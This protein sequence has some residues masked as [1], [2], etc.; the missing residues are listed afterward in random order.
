MFIPIFQILSNNAQDLGSSESMSNIDR[1]VYKIIH[2]F[3]LDPSLEILLVMAFIFLCSRQILTFIHT[4]YSYSILLKISKNIKDT[5]YSRYLNAEMSLIDNLKIGD[6]SN[7]IIVESL[8]AARALMAPIK[9]LSLVI[10]G[11]GSYLLLF[12]ISTKLMLLLIPVVLISA[13]LPFKWIKYSK[14]VGKQFLNANQKVS[15]Y[16][17]SRVRNLELIKISG[18]QKFESKLFNDFT[19]KQIEKTL[20]LKKLA[21]RISLT[22]EPIIIGMCIMLIYLGSKVFLLNMGQISVF[23]LLVLKMIPMQK[24]I[25][26]NWQALSASMGPLHKIIDSINDLSR[27]QE[28]DKGN[29]SILNINSNIEFKDVSFSYDKNMVLNRIN[30]NF[31]IGEI[32]CLLGSSGAGKSTIIDLIKK[33]RSNDKGEIL[34][35]GKNIN[36]Y[37]LDSLRK[38]ISFVPQRPS[39][40]ANTISGH[41]AYGKNGIS[42]EDIRK[43]AALSGADK[44]IDNLQNGYNTII[45]EDAVKLSGGQRQRLDIAR[46]LAG[47]TTILILDEPTNDLD[48]ESI[49]NFYK[50]IIDINNSRDMIIIIV[51]HD[52][53]RIDFADKI[54]IINNG[55]TEF[56]G[57]PDQ[58]KLEKWY[59]NSRQIPS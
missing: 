1:F 50:S 39:Y 19:K 28:Q 5:F 8:N 46:A 29:E 52:L 21:S 43:A 38:M 26:S 51:S 14:I 15:I 22:V 23:L 48:Q 12:L 53:E 13:L 18:T 40:L 55:K 32:T 3:G 25:L 34:I 47:D 57:S 24:D 41:I 4:I 30:I 10:N 42:D 44:F 36:N 33:L 49:N 31:E 17:H 45:G 6:M 56:F 37:T 11:L 2:F 54:A 58:L 20:L 7:V 16:L 59:I 27:N 35:D 9:L